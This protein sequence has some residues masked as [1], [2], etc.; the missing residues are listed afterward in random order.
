V[1]VFAY[2]EDTVEDSESPNTIC[3]QSRVLGDLQLWRR[4]VSE[5]GTP[6]PQPIS[7][8]DVVSDHPGAAFPGYEAFEEAG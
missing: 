6:L 5:L 1:S 8:L 2:S 4:E 3:G 7:L